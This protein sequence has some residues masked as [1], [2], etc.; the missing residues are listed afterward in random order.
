MSRNRRRNSRFSVLMWNCF[1]RVDLDLPRTN[2]AVEGW[3]TAFHNV[4]GDHPSIY[5]FIKDIIREEQNT[6][7]VSNQMLAGTQ[8]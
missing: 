6:A 5:K 7:V 3:H 4:V 2:N 8:T 1:S